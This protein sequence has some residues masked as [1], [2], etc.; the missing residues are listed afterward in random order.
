LFLPGLQKFFPNNGNFGGRLNPQANPAA[1][2]FQN[3]DNRKDF[4]QAR[5]QFQV[6]VQS[7]GKRKHFKL[8]LS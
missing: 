6:L 8:F 5:S 7:S 3:F 1:P 2:D 4:P